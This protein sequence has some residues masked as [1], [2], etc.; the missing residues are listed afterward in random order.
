[1]KKIKGVFIDAE[2]RCLKEIETTWEDAMK[3]HLDDIATIA[4]EIHLEDGRVDTIY[5]GDNAIANG[6]Q[7][8]FYVEGAHQPFFFGN[9]VVLGTDYKTGETV[10]SALTVKE[11]SQK[12]SF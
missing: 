1:M 9:G 12:I 6:L 10:D 2:N 3:T 11:L 7:H 8:R 5:V 4:D